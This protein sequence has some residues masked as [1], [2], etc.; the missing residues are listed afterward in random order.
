[1]VYIVKFIWCASHTI[2]HSSTNDLDLVVMICELCVCELRRE[3]NEKESFR[4]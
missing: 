4:G 1:M 2:L 3:Y